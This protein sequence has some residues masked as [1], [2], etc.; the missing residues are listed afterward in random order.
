M[1]MPASARMLWVRKAIPGVGMTPTMI[2]STPMEQIPE[3]RAFSS[4]YPE[5][6]VSLPMMIRGR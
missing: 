1:T 4:I 6:R 3:T 5:M 2:A